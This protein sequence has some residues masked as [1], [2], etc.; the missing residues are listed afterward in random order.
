MLL[1]DVRFGLRTGLKHKGVTGL[2]V[3]CLAV[4]IGLNTMMF[5]VT[6]AILIRPLPYASPDG[7]VQLETTQ[8]RNGVLHGGLSWLDLQDW[9]DQ[10]KSFSAV[11]AMQT[12]SMTIGGDGV[13]DTDRYS[14]AAISG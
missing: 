9:R 2:A 11:A 10:A 5:S 7:I 6:D 12:R 3:L 8:Q 1:Q 14:G 4:G 13:G